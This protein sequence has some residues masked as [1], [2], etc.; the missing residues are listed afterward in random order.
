MATFEET[1][2]KLKDV[3]D[4]LNKAASK[5]GKGEEKTGG[6]AA[7]EQARDQTAREEKTNDYLK[8]IVGLLGKG[9][10]SLDEKSK[11]GGGIFAGIARALGGVGAGVGKAVGGF[12]GGIAGAAIKGPAFVAAM[13]FLGAGIAAFMAAIAGGAWLASKTFP[14]IAESLKAFDNV[15]GANLKQVGLGMGALGLGLGAE[16]LGGAIGSV[17]NLVGAIADGIGGLF[18]VKSGEDSLIAKM[19]KFGKVKLNH[20]NIKNNAEAMIAYGKAMAMGGAGK[21]LSAVS[22]LAD[23]VLGGLG[24]ALGAVPPLEAL[25][26][27]SLVEI[28][29]DKVKNNS[30]AM[31]EYA[32]AMALGAAAS[33]AKG[34]ASL[35]NIV[36]QVTDGLSKLIPGGKGTLDDQLSSMKKLSSATGIDAAKIKEVTKAMGW[37]AAAMIAGAP[38]SLA[39]GVASFGNLVSNVMDG[40]S[41]LIPGG[42]DVLTNQLDALK[43]MTTESGA[44]DAKK[45]KGVASAM[46]AYAA[47]MLAGA[48][49]SAMKAYASFGNLVSN[50]TDGLSKLIPG[51]KDT[52]T[53][54]LDSLKKMTLAADGIDGKKVKSV[55]E[56][57][58]SYAKAMALG[59]AGKGVGALG[60]IGNFVGG[61]VKALGS[62][63]GIKDKD[64]LEQLKKFSEFNIT[65]KQVEQIKLN[66]KA[67]GSYANAMGELGKVKLPRNFGDTIS[68]IMDGIGGFFSKKKDPMAALENFSKASIDPKK[69][70]TN[71]DALNEFAKLGA[72]VGRLKI[73][74]FVEDIVKALPALEMAIMG[75]K[76]EGSIL[77]SWLGGSKSKILK[78]LADTSIDYAQ[79]RKNMNMLKQTLSEDVATIKDES[80]TSGSTQSADLDGSTKKANVVWQSAL[81]KSIDNLTGVISAA[82]GGN[83]A[84]RQGD[85]I[86]ARTH[87]IS[88]GKGNA[89]ATGS[90]WP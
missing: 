66:A 13:G 53:S 26:T 35:A 14:D 6:A 82:A 2:D 20:V 60:A 67:I 77:P 72:G 75:G 44:I 9:G 41:K 90:R 43:R 45:V 49:A 37:Y 38:A 17:G 40:L 64:P 28:D 79:A 27:F 3:A 15:D 87:N 10:A 12:M 8:Q 18:G 52:L 56:A 5:M 30:E 69:V 33:G 24:K 21:V 89:R 73:D 85:R 81:Q 88:H 59:A 19:E 62:L 57:M 84:I 42:T 29:K 7:A 34:L 4:N 31:M 1:V 68:S 47:A 25:K 80:K 22:T 65:T 83:M 11:K 51:G 71:V 16:G 48:G 39:K 23:G 54:Q 36:T 46:S 55:A 50:I 58:S 86:D 70:K 78:G 32:K 74:D 63:V 76:V 61:A